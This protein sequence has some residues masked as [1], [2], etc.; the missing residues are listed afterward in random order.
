[1]NQTKMQRTKKYL[2]SHPLPR[3]PNITPPPQRHR[4][5]NL[6]W[7]AWQRVLAVVPALALLWLGVLWATLETVPW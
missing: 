7:P 6:A 2:L 1:M 4:R 3:M 5:P